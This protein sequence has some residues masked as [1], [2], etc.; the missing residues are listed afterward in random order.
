VEAAGEGGTTLTGA[1]GPYN[2]EAFRAKATP[3]PVCGEIPDVVFRETTRFPGSNSARLSK[4]SEIKL[5][6]AI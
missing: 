2:D 3:I 4:P 6:R 5:F 1:D